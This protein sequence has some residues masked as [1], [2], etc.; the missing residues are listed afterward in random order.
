VRRPGAEASPGAP[1]ERQRE[2]ME[3][4]ESIGYLT[5]SVPAEERSGVTVYDERL[6]SSG[7]NLVVSGHRPWAALMDMRGRL[8]HEWQLPFAEAWPGR[9]APP[10]ATGDE[11][12]RR[13]HLLPD[14]GLIAIYEGLGIVRL[15]RD[16]RLVWAI[17]G[18]FHHDIAPRDEGGFYALDREA[19]IIP[20]ISRRE[21]VLEDYVAVV[22]EDGTVGRRFSLLEAFERS[23]YAPIL[24]RMDWTGDLFHTNTIEV[25]DGSLSDRSPAFR[26][27]NLLISVLMLD[28]VAVVDPESETVVWA[29]TG[30][31]RQQHQPTMLSGGRM[32]VFDN[33]AGPSVSEVVELDPF[34]QEVFWSYRGGPGRPF[35]TETCGSNQRLPNGDTLITESDNGRAFEVTPDGRIVWEYVNPHRAG[36]ADEFIATLFEVVRMPH[37]WTPDW[38]D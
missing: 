19:K 23:P 21:P 35:Y 6:A 32:L 25:L 27:G 30:L 5:G 4:L 37:G 9:E 13:V 16:S 22:G 12:W 7:L 36:P 31:W 29:L 10:D 11:Y 38:L 2:E 24:A 3:R 17:E 34:T 8:V 1:T 33:K 20:R 14:G 26:E 18:G 28:T 15:D